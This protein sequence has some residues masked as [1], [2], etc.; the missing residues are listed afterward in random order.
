MT[1]AKSSQIKD[2]ESSAATLVKSVA[3]EKTLNKSFTELSIIDEKPKKAGGKT[4]ATKKF[5]YE[6]ALFPNKLVK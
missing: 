2:F 6:P 5:L 3:Q 4:T 1:M